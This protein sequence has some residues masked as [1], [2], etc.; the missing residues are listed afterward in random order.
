LDDLT[1]VRH[2]TG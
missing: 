1:R 2:V